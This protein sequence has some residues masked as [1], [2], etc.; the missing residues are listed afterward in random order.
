MDVRPRVLL[1]EPIHLEAMAWLRARAEV[2]VAHGLREDALMPVVGRSKELSS[3]RPGASPN[4]C[5]ANL[6]R[7]RQFNDPEFTRAVTGILKLLQRQR[8][9]EGT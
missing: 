1:F 4:G 8:I 7:F 9:A 5:S 2:I 3:A 6:N